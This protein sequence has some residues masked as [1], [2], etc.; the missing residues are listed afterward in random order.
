M[1]HIMDVKPVSS[2]ESSSE[3]VTTTM[4]CRQRASDVNMWTHTC[5]HAAPFCNAT[6]R[7]KVTATATCR[8]GRCWVAV[9]LE[10][11]DARAAAGECTA[12]TAA[13]PVSAALAVD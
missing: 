2:W 5:R 8:W 9:Q 13:A 1:N 3:G 7:E 4:T 12:A 6:S 11:Q 10:L